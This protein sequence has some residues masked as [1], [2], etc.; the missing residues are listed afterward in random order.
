MEFY[1]STY[2]WGGPIL[3]HLIGKLIVAPLLS[4]FGSAASCKELLEVWRSLRNLRELQYLELGLETLLCWFSFE[5]TCVLATPNDSHFRS[6][7]AQFICRIIVQDSSV[8]NM[9]NLS[10]LSRPG[11]EPVVKNDGLSRYSVVNFIADAT[12][13]KTTDRNAFQVADISWVESWC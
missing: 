2:H 13:F 10:L 3:Y 12:N 8:S 9:Q 5:P 4:M 7:S 6:S 11:C 1:K